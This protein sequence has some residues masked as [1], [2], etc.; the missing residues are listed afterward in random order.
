MQVSEYAIKTENLVK[1]Y[2]HDTTALN[3]IS[4]KIR[5]GDIVG[6]V[7]PN[8]SGKTTTIKILTNLIRPTSGHAYI[9]GVD[10]NRNPKK[11][12]RTVGALIE[13][14]G[15]YQYLTPHEML[16]YLGKVRRMKDGEIKQRI[17]EVLELVRLAD[18]EHKRLGSFSTG[19]QRR[20]GIATTILHN[21]EILI[22]DEPV[23]GLDP[24]GIRDVRDVR[25]V[26]ELIKRFQGEGITILL[27]S[28]LLQEVNDTCHSVI[29]LDKGRVVAYDSI[30]NIKSR[31]D[32]N[33]IDVEFLN[34]L[35]EED[36][37]KIKSIEPVDSLDVL[38]EHVQIHFDGKR[39]TCSQILSRLVSSGFPI[40]SYGPETVRLEDFY[41]SIMS[42][43]KDV[44]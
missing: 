44:K 38:N 22:L 41:S 32:L 29:F 11:A 5:R 39:I 35:A 18:W 20:F 16:T 6:Y 7:G 8:G 14:P 10:V 33:I 26:R 15:V 4:F 27:S 17:C 37:R 30:G 2:N 43:E 19:M 34:P 24:K 31:V 3:G 12:L 25:D 42:D 1:R 28:H 9:N 40:V 13:V 36:I 23:I 21:P